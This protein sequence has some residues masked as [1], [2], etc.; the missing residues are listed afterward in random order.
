MF[1]IH[2]LTLYLHFFY[3]VYVFLEE[4]DKN[5]MCVDQYCKIASMFLLYRNIAPMFFF[6]WFRRQLARRWGSFIFT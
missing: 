3:K 1:A 6:F 2:I 4:V 5:L